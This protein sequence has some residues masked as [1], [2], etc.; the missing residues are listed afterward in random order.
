[1]DKFT[2][3]EGYV[4]IIETLLSMNYLKYVKIDKW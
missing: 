3:N 1:M 2:E 4:A